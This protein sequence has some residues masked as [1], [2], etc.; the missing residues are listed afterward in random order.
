MANFADDSRPYI[1]AKN[2][3]DVIQ[4]LEQASLPLFR[5]F[6]NSLL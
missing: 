3:E 1:S 6:E 4:F 5:W 2:G